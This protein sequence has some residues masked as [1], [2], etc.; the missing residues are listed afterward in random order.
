MQR[1]L[2]SMDRTQARL[3]G[4]SRNSPYAMVRAV[5]HPS[6]VIGCRRFVS[7]QAIAA[8]S[9]N[10]TTSVSPP[11]DAVR[12]WR[13]AASAGQELP[14]NARVVTRSRKSDAG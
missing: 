7:A 5:S 6:V 11:Q 3:G 14:S 2:Y 1:A 9:S 13:A 8:P 10:Y 4:I 12:S